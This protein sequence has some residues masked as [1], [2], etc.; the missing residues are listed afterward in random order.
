MVFDN[1]R[2]LVGGAFKMLIV[3]MSTTHT[4][5]SQQAFFTKYSH[6]TYKIN[7]EVDT[8]FLQI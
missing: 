3:E 8:R 7:Y 4:Y 5:I 6:F 2:F 1:S